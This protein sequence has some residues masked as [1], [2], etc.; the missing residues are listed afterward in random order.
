MKKRVTDN[1]FISTENHELDFIMRKYRI[2]R[3][4]S[5]VWIK[6]CNNS[7]KKFME[8]IEESKQVF[9]DFI[10]DI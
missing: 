8:K 4:V 7:R 6:E 1:D 2:S 3:K 5:R 10:D 9:E